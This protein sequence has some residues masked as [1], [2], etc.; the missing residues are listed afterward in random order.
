MNQTSYASNL[1]GFM[2]KKW[3]SFPILIACFGLIYLFFT[4]LQKETAPYDDRSSLV[5]TA[6]TAEGSSYEYTN[7]FMQELSRLIDDSIPEKKVS[8]I[9]TAPGFN[10]SATNSGRVRIALVQPD[11]RERSQKEIAE[12]LTKWT[13]KYPEAKTS[14]TEQPTIAVNK[15]GGLAHSIHYSS[16]KL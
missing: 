16:T 1:E 9:I 8:L 6:T 4:I 7:R 12:K 15:R 14:V 11:D 13:K 5:M 10:A 3:L 2:K